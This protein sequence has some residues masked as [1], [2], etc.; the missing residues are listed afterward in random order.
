MNVFLN[1]D[2]KSAQRLLATKVELRKLRAQLRRHALRR[3][4]GQSVQ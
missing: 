1:G 3:L 2:M 4:A